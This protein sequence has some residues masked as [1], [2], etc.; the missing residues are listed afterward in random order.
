MA[1]VAVARGRTAKAR[2]DHVGKRIGWR[3]NTRAGT[4]LGPRLAGARD[5]DVSLAEC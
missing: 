3:S 5:G 4:P 2:E 1:Y